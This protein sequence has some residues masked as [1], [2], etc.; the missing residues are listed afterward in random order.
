LLCSQ[1]KFWDSIVDSRGAGFHV[2]D[3]FTD[4]GEAVP[5]TDPMTTRSFIIQHQQALSEPSTERMHAH[6]SKGLS[7]VAFD[8]TTLWNLEGTQVDKRTQLNNGRIFS[9]AK[10]AGS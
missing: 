7:S 5:T 4:G 1:T 6:F 8:G 9:A 10:A 2:S 3:V